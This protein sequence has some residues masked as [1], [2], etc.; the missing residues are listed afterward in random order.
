MHNL[1]WVLSK[2]TGLFPQSRK[3]DKHDK[4]LPEYPELNLPFDMGNPTEK[5]LGR[6]FANSWS[7]ARWEEERQFQK[8]K[9]WVSVINT[10]T[11]KPM[12]LSVRVLNAL[13]A[14]K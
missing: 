14:R 5:F 6:V 12:S 3:G 2:L 9:D 7:L 1:V 10:T 13:R 8:G 4:R 11:P